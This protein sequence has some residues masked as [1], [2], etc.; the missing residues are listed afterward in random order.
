CYKS[1]F[2]FLKEMFLSYQKYL[3]SFLWKGLWIALIGY[4][5]SYFFQILIDY[6]DLKT[7]F[8]YMAVLSLGYCFLEMMRTYLSQ[9]KMKEMI[10]LQKAMDEDYVFQSFMNMLKQ[11]ETFYRQDDGV[12]Q[13]QLLSLFELTEMSLECFEKF[14]LDGMFFVVLWIGMWFLNIWMTCIVSVVLLIIV[15]MSYRRLK[16]F[17]TLNKNYLEAHIHFGHHVLELIENH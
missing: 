15:L 12:I 6:I 8:F 2:Q 5:S 17:Q 16:D 13:S 3:T 9:L 10:H 7:P 4:G 11:P 1:Y 14:F